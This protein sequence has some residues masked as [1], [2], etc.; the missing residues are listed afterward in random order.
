MSDIFEN[1]KSD[2]KNQ[3][4]KTQIDLVGIQDKAEQ[5]IQLQ[6][7]KLIF[8]NL[9]VSVAFGLVWITIGLL[10]YFLSDR[11]I[12]FYGSMVSMG[13]IMLFFLGLMWLSVQYRNI[14]SF[15]EHRKY[16]QSNISKLKLR[17]WMMTK[18]IWIYLVLLTVTF[19][20]YFVDVLAD[21][22]LWV[23]ILAYISVPAYGLF[24]LFM[25]RK[26]NREE[27]VKVNTLII[28]LEEWESGL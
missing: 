5:T 28:D 1:L 16:I 26:K 11:S 18:G 21:T 15:S 20:F 22:D 2:W 24:V 7:R 14:D 25:I 8:T 9:K 6:Q 13:L 23:K 4:M 19:Y 27:L 10:W 17:K 3:P 12:Y